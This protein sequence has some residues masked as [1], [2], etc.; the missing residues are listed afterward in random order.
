MQLFIQSAGATSTLDVAPTDTVASLKQSVEDGMGLPIEHQHL[1]SRGRALEDGR[2][3]GD[4]SIQDTDVIDV[5]LRV[6]GGRV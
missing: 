5:C 6:R 4:Y 2:T 1:L 3:L